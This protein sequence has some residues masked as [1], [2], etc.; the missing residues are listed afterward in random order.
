MPKKL[1][2]EFVKDEFWR[3]KN[4]ILLETE[5]KNNHTPMRYIHNNIFYIIY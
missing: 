5:Y 2:I 3:L 1:T 4:Y